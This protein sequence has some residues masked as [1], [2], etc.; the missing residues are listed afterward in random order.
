M[1]AEKAGGTQQDADGILRSPSAKSSAVQI[2]QS[3]TGQLIQVP[4]KKL[5]PFSLSWTH[6]VFLMS[7]R[8]PAERS[9]YEIESTSEDW[10]VRELRRQFDSCLYERLAL[11]RDKEG[12]RRLAREGQTIAKPQDILKE[13]LVLEFLGLEERER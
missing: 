4:A 1:I 8:N 11:S 2:A 13:P 6:Y 10:T 3:T 12:I 5:R 9:F 7:I